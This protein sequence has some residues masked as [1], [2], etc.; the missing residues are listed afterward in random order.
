MDFMK[1]E[2]LVKLIVDGK[3]LVEPQGIAEEQLS[4]SEEGKHYES[5]FRSKR[6]S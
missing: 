4:E 3:Q 2:E 5:I 1:V 6:S